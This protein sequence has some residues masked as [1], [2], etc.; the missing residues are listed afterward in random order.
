[1]LYYG[2]ISAENEHVIADAFDDSQLPRTSLSPAIFS[3]PGRGTGSAGAVPPVV[4]QLD[5]ENKTIHMAD[6][7]LAHYEN[8]KLISFISQR[9]E[10]YGY[11]PALPGSE[12]MHQSSPSPMLFNPDDSRSHQNSCEETLISDQAQNSTLTVIFNDY[13]FLISN[14]M[15]F[16]SPIFHSQCWHRLHLLILNRI[17]LLPL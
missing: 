7:I 17:V 2:N 3:R 12:S 15:F 1:M 6:A 16:Y 9:P 4:L 13:P 11:T 14:S 8:L 5:R 10:E